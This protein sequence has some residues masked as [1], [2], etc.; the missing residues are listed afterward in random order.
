MIIAI[1]GPAG[2]GKSTTARALADR[3]DLLYIDTGAM[4]RAF[5]L[6]FLR[7]DGASES[8]DIE[9]V[10]KRLVRSVSV[11]LRAT[12]TGTDV[13]LDDELVNESIRTTEV[14]RAASMIAKFAVVRAAMVA[15]QHELARN[16]VKDGRGAILE[17]RDIGTVV[18]PDAD[19]KIF[20]DADLDERAR[21]RYIDFG[22]TNESKSEI[23][24]ALA[25]RDNEDTNR[26]IAPLVAAD[27]AVHIDTT[28]LTFEQQVDQIVGLALKRNL[29]N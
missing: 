10:V 5:G 26:D 14:G 6:A 12:P 9:S 13:I 22:D 7:T 19:L 4:Y 3:L 27:D 21:R 17:G 11:E 15:Q 8:T 2:S 29:I 23:R 24:N 28:S 16:A 20:L 25:E 18:F 1:D